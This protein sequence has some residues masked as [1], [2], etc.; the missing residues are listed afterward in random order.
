MRS[1]LPPYIGGILWFGVDDAASNVYVPMYCGINN[2]PECFSINNG[3]LLEYSPTSAFWIYNWVANYAYSRYNY[4]MS[5]IRKVQSH[6]E[7]NFQTLVPA[8]DK[9][10][11]TMPE[12][13]AREFLTNFSITQ[14]ENSTTAWKKLGEYLLVKYMDGNI[15]KEENGKF[16]QNDKAIPPGIIRPG[17]PEEFLRQIVKENPNLRTKTEEEMNNRKPMNVPVEVTSP[18][19]QSN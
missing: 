4:M 17:Y 8:M 15:K 19:L 10:A 13:N 16:L 2:I 5:D 14:A 11:L 1:W 9:T 12:N 6:W 7:N 3:S 18:E